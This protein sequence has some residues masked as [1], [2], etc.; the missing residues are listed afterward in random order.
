MLQ[1]TLATC[2]SSMEFFENFSNDDDD[3]SLN[4]SEIDFS[5]LKIIKTEHLN[6]KKKGFEH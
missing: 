5:S 4:R 6:M 3:D 1:H 2:T